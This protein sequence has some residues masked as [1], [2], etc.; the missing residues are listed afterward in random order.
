MGTQANTSGVS[1]SPS[2]ARPPFGH[3]AHLPLMS[4]GRQARLCAPARTPRAHCP[5]GQ[6]DEAGAGAAAG[7]TPQTPWGPTRPGRH[8]HREV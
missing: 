5:T 3:E 7:P 2:L 6:R 1:E 4:E 8:L